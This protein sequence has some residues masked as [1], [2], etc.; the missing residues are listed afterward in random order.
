[1]AVPLASL[2]IRERLLDLIA[3]EQERSPLGVWAVETKEAEF[4]GWFMLL[5]AKEPD[6][7][8]GF[9][10]RRDQWGKGYATEAARRL[11]DFALYDLGY[12]AVLGTVR[13]ENV[14]SARVLEKLGFQRTGSRMEP[15]ASGPGEVAVDLYVL[16]G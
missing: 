5:K 3:R 1:M 15:A 8:L 6:P 12:S 11:V 7:E 2:R 4:V 13:R 16:W 14:A 9:M 10:I